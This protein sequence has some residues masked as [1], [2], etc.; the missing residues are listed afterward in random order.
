MLKTSMYISLNFI[1]LKFTGKQR[2]WMIWCISSVFI[3]FDVYCILS[4][5][6]KYI[7][8]NTNERY[9]QII[10]LKCLYLILYI[11]CY[12]LSYLHF[13]F[14]FVCVFHFQHHQNEFNLNAALNEL[15]KYVVRYNDKVWYPLSLLFLSTIIN[16]I[17]F[18][19]SWKLI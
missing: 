14:I 18:I 2:N 12:S 6:F 16:C 19:F 8:K 1:S 5:I 15:Y 11:Y 4:N 10:T 17:S 13:Y 9:D 7:L 3:C